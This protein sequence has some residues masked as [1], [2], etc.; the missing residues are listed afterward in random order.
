M[1][2]LFHFLQHGI[3]DNLKI[4][5][6]AT[7]VEELFGPPKDYSHSDQPVI[8]KYDTLEIHFDQEAETENQRQVW[9]IGVYFWNKSEPL[10]EGID[11]K[12]WFPRHGTSEPELLHK[13]NELN[14]EY[15]MEPALCSDNCR[16][17]VAGEARVSVCFDLEGEEPVI[18]KM[19][20]S[21]YPK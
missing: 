18:E 21:A 10:F 5:F 16:T 15:A 7:E 4:G 9:L 20:V 3:L 14:I 19:L 2:T 11:W 8:W 12:G 1:S 17:Y 6:T 13:F